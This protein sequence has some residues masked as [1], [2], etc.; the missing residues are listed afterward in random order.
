MLNIKTIKIIYKSNLYIT[1]C[2]NMILDSPNSLLYI[3]PK[4]AKKY[5]KSIACKFHWFG[6][7]LDKLIDENKIGSYNENNNSFSLGI[8]T[9]GHH[10]CICSEYS[11][12]FDILL[13]N[14]MATNTLAY[15]YMAY[16]SDEVPESEWLKLEQLHNYLNFQIIEV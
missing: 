15:H 12:G 16:H 1:H 10:T 13:P 7:L 6:R 2:L 14:H 8:H 3:E 11:T 4:N 9:L 5:N